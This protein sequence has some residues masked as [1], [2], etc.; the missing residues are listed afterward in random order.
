[1]EGTGSH[2][3][4]VNKEFVTEDW[5]FIRGAPALVDEPLYHIPTVAFGSGPH[6]GS[7]WLGLCSNSGTSTNL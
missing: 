7:T 3:L 1:M 4:K 5:S 6:R 2:D